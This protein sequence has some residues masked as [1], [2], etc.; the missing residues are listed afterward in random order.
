ML[1]SL[2][3]KNG[4]QYS[5][6]FVSKINIC[7]VLSG[8]CCSGDRTLQSTCAQ[9][10]LQNFV[11]FSMTSS[12][13]V[14]VS[15]YGTHVWAVVPYTTKI[16]TV[17]YYVFSVSISLIRALVHGQCNTSGINTRIKVNGQKLETVSSKYLGSFITNEGFKPELLSR[18][19]Q[20]TAALTRLKPVWN[21]GSIS[22]N[23]KIR[24]MRFLVTSVFL[25]ACESWTLTAELQRGI[26]AMETK[27]CRKILRISYKDHVTKAQ[28]CAKIQRAIGPHEEPPG[29]LEE[30]QSAVVWTCLPFI[31]SSQNHHPRHSERGKKKRQTEEEVGGKT[32]G[33]E[34]VWSSQ[35]PRGQWKTEK[36]GGNWL[37]SH[38]RCPN[39][40]CG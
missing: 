13:L 8:W 22:L 35:S 39:D 19:A 10:L 33:K 15:Y 40:P 6:L 4:G 30:M 14:H 9:H 37:W 29:H 27:C 36:N 24:L 31:S 20:T 2:W 11:S 1:F 5:I 26:R 7:D 28:V 21:D 25:C 12:D 32:S 3:T 34:Q 23:S 38:L 17:L 16:K 18:I